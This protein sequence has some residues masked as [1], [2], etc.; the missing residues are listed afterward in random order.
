MPKEY[1]TSIIEHIHRSRSRDAKVSET[2]LACS[3]V[4]VLCQKLRGVK[5]VDDFKAFFKEKFIYPPIKTWVD[6]WDN[7]E[8]GRWGTTTYQTNPVRPIMEAFIFEYPQALLDVVKYFEGVQ[9]ERLKA[10]FKEQMRLQL[11]AVVFE[12]TEEMKIKTVQAITRLEEHGTKI[13]SE[14]PEKYHAITTVVNHLNQL[15]GS[16]TLNSNEAWGI[17]VFKLRFLTQLHDQDSVLE[18]QRNQISKWIIDV[19]HRVSGATSTFF[20]ETTSKK[21]V[22]DIQGQVIFSR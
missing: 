22:D 9:D 20:K 2:P 13:K 1:V 3:D 21:I 17:F 4:N 11:P 19:A 10:L 15:L 14:A 18:S 6:H 5:T 16:L 7:H 8:S 12:L